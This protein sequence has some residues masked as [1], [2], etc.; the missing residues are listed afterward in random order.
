[1][2][3]RK[4]IR[5]ELE[6]FMN[7]TNGIKGLDILNFLTKIPQTRAEVDWIAR[8]HYQI[9]SLRDGDGSSGVFEK[10]YL[11]QYISEFN[12]KFGEDP[13]FEIVGDRINVLNP[14]YKEWADSY[15]KM[16]SGIF[17]RSK[18]NNS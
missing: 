17:A 3:I 4:L 6:S 9:S 13:I 18:E 14:K 10:D 12:S 2:N 11:I 1:M 8:P 7:Q 5:E 16:K 15:V